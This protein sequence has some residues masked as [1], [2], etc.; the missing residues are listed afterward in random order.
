ME[1]NV[2][3]VMPP[4]VLVAK[5]SALSIQDALVCDW[6]EESDYP[7]ATKFMGRFPLPTFQRDPCW[8]TKQDIAFVSSAWLGFDIGSYMINAR[9][10]ESQRGI[11]APLSDILID[12]QQRI[13]AFSRYTNNEFKMFGYYWG[14]LNRNEQRRFLETTFNRKVVDSNNERVLRETYNRLNFAGTRHLESEK[15]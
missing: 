14:Q 1:V 7:W 6:L 9:Q 8:T 3:N 11:M 12:G 10:G 13:N 4:R 5:N 15:A 2:N